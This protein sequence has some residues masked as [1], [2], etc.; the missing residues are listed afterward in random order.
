MANFPWR[1]DMNYFK[2]LAIFGCSLLTFT[3]SFAN[4]K[5]KNQFKSYVKEHLEIVNG[6]IIQI[7]GYS[8]SYKF[9]RLDSKGYSSSHDDNYKIDS[10]QCVLTIDLAKSV[11]TLVDKS[12]DLKIKKDLN[13]FHGEL[14]VGYGGVGWKTWHFTE[15]LFD[16]DGNPN[17]QV[18]GLSYDKAGNLGSKGSGS[19]LISN[20]N[21]EKNFKESFFCAFANLKNE[22]GNTTR[23]E[24]TAN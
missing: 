13:T 20:Y 22:L 2:T 14:E 21:I 7:E 10:K 5:A 12:L 6:Q 17:I 23:K 4:L 11:V 1:K 24:I 3:S 8:G 15:R 9:Q 16:T 18:F 19:V